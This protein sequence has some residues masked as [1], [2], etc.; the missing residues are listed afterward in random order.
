MTK[1]SV[2]RLKRRMKKIIIIIIHKITVYVYT[3]YQHNKNVNPN[4]PGS[5]TVDCIFL[6]SSS[7]HMVSFTGGRR[8]EPK[9]RHLPKTPPW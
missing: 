7:E 1:P 5:S 8:V 6:S 9:E 4:V 3:C 2:G